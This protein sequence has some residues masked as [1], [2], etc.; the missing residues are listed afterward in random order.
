[1]QDAL[2]HGLVESLDGALKT[3]GSLIRIASGNRLADAPHVGS[4][5]RS[6]GLAARVALETLAM[7]LLRRR[8][9]GHGVAVFLPVR[10]ER[11]NAL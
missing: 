1:M 9:F 6:Y 3:L 7:A 8:V 10:A 5:A 11:V 2:G 4:N